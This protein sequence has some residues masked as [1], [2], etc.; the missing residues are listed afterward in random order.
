M[1]CFADEK[2]VTYIGQVTYQVHSGWKDVCFPSYV[3]L[4]T[5]LIFFFYLSFSIQCIPFSANTVGHRKFFCSGEVFLAEVGRFSKNIWTS[6]P[7]SIK[8]KT[9]LQIPYLLPLT[10][11]GITS[12]DEG[13]LARLVATTFFIAVLFVISYTNQCLYIANSILNRARWGN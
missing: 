10:P 13:V 4:V 1:W 8:L 11:F 7:K 3:F 2:G 9:H 12:G 6:F 5:L